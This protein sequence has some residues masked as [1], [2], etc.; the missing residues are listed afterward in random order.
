MKDWKSGGYLI[1]YTE[2][3]IKPIL[4]HVIPVI[5]AV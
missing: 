2:A 1:R 3:I 5:V 4:M